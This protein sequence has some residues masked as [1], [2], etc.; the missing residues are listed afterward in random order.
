MEFIEFIQK[1]FIFLV[2][3]ILG[4]I[5][6]NYYNP[7][8]QRHYY[9]EFLYIILCSFFSLLT[10]DIVFGLIKL[11]F[12]CFIFKSLDIIRYISTMDGTMPT[13]NMIFSIIIAV[14]YALIG[15]KLNYHNTL[16]KIANKF[17]ITYRTNNTTVWEQA[18]AIKSYLVV[19]DYV[20]K[21]TYFGQ[22]IEFS[23]NSEIRELLL[24]NVNVYDEESNFLYHAEEVFLSRLH[25][26][27]SIETY[28]YKNNQ[29]EADQIAK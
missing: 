3:G 25:N 22:V 8:K 16:F 11:L 23:D 2:P 27:F 15:T 10:V 21:N 17:K 24:N 6:F 14:T 7:H 19:R 20:T 29:M 18:L 13:S 5:I 1:F 12:P 28:N 9:I 4:L 26:E